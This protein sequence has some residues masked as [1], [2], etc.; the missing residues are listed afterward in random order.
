MK[1]YKYI[2]AII[3]ACMLLSCSNDLSEK[4]FSYV[5][6]QSYEY[7][8]D[9][10]NPI[11]A[12]VYRPVRDFIGHQ[13]WYMAQESS[14]D[15]IVMPANAS[16]WDDGG[17]Y[18]RM[19]YHTWN[20]EQVHIGNLWNTLYF[21]IT[22]ANKV[23]EQIEND[24]VP[25]PSPEI[26]T[27]GLS[28]VRAMRA[29]YY[30]M[31][32]DNFGEAPL[33]KEVT[34]EMP[35]KNTRKEIYDFIVS[36]LKDVHNILPETHGGTQYGRINK[37]AAKTI[38]ANIYLNAEVYT[39]QPAWEECLALCDEIIGSNKFNLADNYNAAFRNSGIENLP[40]IIFTI[41]FDR[42]FAEGN[43]IHMFSWHGEL[44]KKYETE[45]TPWGSGSAMGIS[46]FID[47]YHPNDTRLEDSWLMGEQ[48]AADGTLLTGVYDML[49][50]PLTF[51][52]DLPNGEYTLETEGYRMN[53]FEVIAGSTHNSSTDFPLFRYSQVLLMKAECLLRTNQGG[54]GV[55]VTQVRNRAFKE[56][57]S[58][59]T[60]TDSQLRENSVYQ[61]G[62]V[63][64]YIITKPGNQ[65]PVVL[66]RLLDELG[67]EFA[68]EGFRRRDMIRFGT[69]TTKSWLSHEPQGNYRTV[70]PI[71]EATLT[72]NP[73][74][75]QN[76]D[77]K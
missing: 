55:L 47:T 3:S 73:N 12:S 39:G 22:L 51:T 44:K 38:L 57:P 50:L 15:A 20:S 64:N 42:D 26:K 18:K 8:E 37:W 25:A 40:E 36:E 33:V 60:V 61:Y 21:G 29:F 10:F 27:L 4:V 43:S 71:P 68:W 59:A 2:S 1:T 72:S 11:V 32:C 70:F 35:S 58:M 16:G 17:I 45:A 14:S 41:P 6:D 9:D 28:E 7:T 24:I 30:W 56:N 52:K 69:Y 46:Q 66:G 77:Y 74:L 48:Y 5:T 67:W 31:V 34:E 23:I 54:A 62:Y 65:D 53:K 75:V 19:H 63:E 13:N 76:P 49:D